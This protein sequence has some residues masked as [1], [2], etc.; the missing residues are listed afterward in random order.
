MKILAINPGSTSTKIALYGNKENIFTKNIEHNS[1]QLEKFSNIIEQKG[2][3]LDEIKKI[4]LEQKVKIKDIDIFVGRGGLLKPI[5]SGTYEVNEQ[6]IKDL[7]DGFQG[8]HASNLGGLIAKELSNEN[9]K[10]CYI[11]DP[12]VVDELS[13]VARVSGIKDI[14]RKSIF[15]ALNQKAVGKRYAR[16]IGKEY[17]QLNLVIAHMGGGTSV[18]LHKKGKVIETNNAIGGDGAFSP[19][20]AGALPAFEFLKFQDGKTLEEIKVSL[21]GRGGLVSY[22]NTSDV[23][24]VEKLKKEGNKEAGIVIEAMA[25]SIAKEIG[26]FST[27]VSGNVD[28]IILTGGVAYSEFVTSYIKKKVEYIAPVT[29]YPGE[30][31]MQALVEGALRVVNKEEEVKEYSGK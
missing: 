31:E 1:T 9:N 24:E 23:R 21:K 28:Q 10:K 22:F 12:V 6:M 14:S 20:R 17:T 4:L 25:Y 19:E 8:E 27:V 7:K 16:E 5:P 11:V 3:R 18:G 29:F 13:D 15:H 26:S 2:F 30:D